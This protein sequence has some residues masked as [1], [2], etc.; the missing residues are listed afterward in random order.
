MVE[1]AFMKPSLFLVPLAPHLL[2]SVLNEAG[3]YLQA[4]V[5]QTRG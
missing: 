5:Y 2:S 4:L 1:A 3:G